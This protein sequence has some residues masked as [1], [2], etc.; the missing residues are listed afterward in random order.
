MRGMG[1]RTVLSESGENGHKATN[2]CWLFSLN[3]I[4]VELSI[5]V[6]I[7]VDTR[8]AR[9][10]GL[11]FSRL[12]GSQM[13]RYQA[14]PSIWIDFRRRDEKTEIVRVW[15]LEVPITYWYHHVWFTWDKCWKFHHAE[16]Q[17]QYA[18]NLEIV[19]C[20]LYMSQEL[21][22]NLTGKSSRNPHHPTGGNI[23]GIASYSRKSTKRVCLARVWSTCSCISGVSADSMWCES[24]H[25]RQTHMVV[26]RWSVAH[27]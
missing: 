4:F 2:T 16:Q 24:L 13:I 5:W 22:H 10:F 3:Q 15:W 23:N 11:D 9:R 17:H 6:S 14:G 12:S 21:H 19:I 27:W 18:M 7:Y 8:R 1:E 20:L 25:A 26:G